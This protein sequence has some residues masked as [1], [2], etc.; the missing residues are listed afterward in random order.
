M[1]TSAKVSVGA[2]SI[3]KPSNWETTDTIHAIP[4]ILDSQTAPAG[5]GTMGVAKRPAK[6]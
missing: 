2:L 3:A 5:F 1:I 4:L 6:A